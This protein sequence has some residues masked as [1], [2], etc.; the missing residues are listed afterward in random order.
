MRKDQEGR[1]KKGGKRISNEKN[2]LTNK[3][4]RGVG[5]KEPTINSLLGEQKIR[6]TEG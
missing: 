5:E 1:R 4:G 6:Y 3:H 2:Q